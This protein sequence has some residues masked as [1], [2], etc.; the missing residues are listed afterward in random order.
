MFDIIMS[1]TGIIFLSPLLIIISLAVYTRLGKPVF[2]KQKR[3]GLKG[4]PFRMYK[5][6]SMTNARD[7][8]GNLLENKE[9]LTP[10]GLKLRNSS[11]DELPEFI[12]VLKGEM[13]LV[14]PRPLKM[15]YLSRYSA[16]QARRHD[17]KPGITG[18]AQVSGRNTLAWEKRFELD[19][20]YI[21]HQSLWL[22]I[23]IIFKTVAAVLFGQRSSPEND[24]VITDPFLGS[25]NEQEKET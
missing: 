8:M 2:F 11:L 25:E 12:N 1:L 24:R 14:G 7:E 10:F 19:V 22:D 5:F 15:E 9:R 20:W 18:L 17:V 13:S 21:E 3:P 4:K 6:R 16:Q 23:K